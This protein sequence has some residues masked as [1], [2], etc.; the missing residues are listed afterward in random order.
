MKVQFSKCVL[1]NLGKVPITNGQI[2]FVTDTNEQYIDTNNGR[3]KITDLMFISNKEELESMTYPLPNK[4]Y[5]VV[6]ENE[7]MFYCLGTWQSVK[8]V[9]ME[10]ILTKDNETPYTPTKD[11]HPATKKY[12]DEQ[13][14]EHECKTFTRTF[15]A[16]D[17]QLN[18]QDYILTIS[19][20]E[21]LLSK[22]I[23]MGLEM[24]EDEEYKSITMYGSKLL[25]NGSLIVL[26]D[27]KFKGRIILKGGN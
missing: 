15:V 25:T 24:L 3:N 13:I 2:I 21:H 20:S 26:S 14:E 8:S 4:L 6:S 23:I 9:N 12:V 10:N 18:G 16:N 1:A 17:W 11:Y 27:L 7:I 5:Y 19:Q 22:P